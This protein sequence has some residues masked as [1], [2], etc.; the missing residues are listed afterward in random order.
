M[1]KKKEN[2]NDL[3]FLRQQIAVCPHVQAKVVL[4]C[5]NTP[6]WLGLRWP[7]PEGS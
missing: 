2:N 7:L 5:A 4:P 3:S 6:G 1:A